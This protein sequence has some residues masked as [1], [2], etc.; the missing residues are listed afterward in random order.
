[1]FT[2]FKA[3]FC[4]IDFAKFIVFI[5]K[6]TKWPNLLVAIATVVTTYARRISRQWL[7]RLS[8]LFYKK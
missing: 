7:R 5:I 3:S 6:T 1:M 8:T 2:A 4:A